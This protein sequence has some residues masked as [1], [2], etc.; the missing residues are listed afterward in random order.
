[1]IMSNSQLKKYYFPNKQIENLAKKYFPNLIAFYGNKT[2]FENKNLLPNERLILEKELTEKMVSFLN[3]NKN[4]FY[5]F[6]LTY[7][8]N[9]KE[10]LAEIILQSIMAYSKLNNPKYKTMDIFLD[11]NSMLY[12]EN[13]Y[14]ATIQGWLEDK[15]TTILNYIFIMKEIL[16]FIKNFNFNFFDKN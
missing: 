3:E 16:H 12:F 13:L 15:N 11:S 4:I 2:L 10:I 8:I 7:S 6:A 5:D 14:P 1:M 9:D